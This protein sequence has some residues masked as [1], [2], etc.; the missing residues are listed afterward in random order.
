MAINPVAPRF[1]SIELLASQHYSLWRRAVFKGRSILNGRVNRRVIDVLDRMFV[2]F[3][4]DIVIE[5][6]F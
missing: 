6:E 4:Y 3:Q 2:T 1:E 5:Q